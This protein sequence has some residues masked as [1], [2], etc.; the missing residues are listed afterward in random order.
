MWCDGRCIII[1][2]TF[3]FIDFELRRYHYRLIIKMCLQ[4]QLIIGAIKML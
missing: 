1:Y 2:S 3:I 4:S